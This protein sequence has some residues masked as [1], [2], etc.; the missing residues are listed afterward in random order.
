MASRR[1]KEAIVTRSVSVLHGHENWVRGLSWDPVGKYLAS[2]G[3]DN[4]LILW[5][6]SDWK[7]ERRI[8][9]PFSGSTSMC[10]VHV[11]VT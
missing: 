7:L 10:T 9:G 2:S 4:A 8:T 5:R 6:T 1:V 3:D 11:L